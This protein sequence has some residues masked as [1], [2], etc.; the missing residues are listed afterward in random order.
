MARHLLSLLLLPQ[1]HNGKNIPV[2]P[3]SGET[4]PLNTGRGLRCHDMVMITAAEGVLTRLDLYPLSLVSEGGDK[5]VTIVDPTGTW[6]RLGSTV[7]AT[8][9]MRLDTKVTSQKAGT[10]RPPTPQPPGS[11]TR[12]AVLN[13]LLQKVPRIGQNSL[14]LWNTAAIHSTWKG[15]TSRPGCLA[16]L[17]PV[18][19]PLPIRWAKSRGTP[20]GLPSQIQVGHQ[21]A[22]PQRAGLGGPHNDPFVAVTLGEPMLKSMAR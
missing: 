11:K 8:H 5:T 14:I 10:G 15:T 22:A 13:P 9:T 20:R 1:T 4:E 3:I 19:R 16:T 12:I 17:P 6:R 18:T 7:Y 2:L 21:S